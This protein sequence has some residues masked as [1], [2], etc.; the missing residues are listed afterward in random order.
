MMNFF[1]LFSPNYP[2]TIIYMLQSVE[3][4]AGEFIKWFWRTENFKNVAYRR[5]LDKTPKA[6]LLLAVLWLIIVALFILS[7]WLAVVGGQKLMIG[8]GLLVL[9]PVASAHLLVLPLAI[10][11]VLL[12]RPIE[13]RRIAKA[14]HIFA[15]FTGSKIVVLGSYGKTSTKELVATAIGSKLQ[16]ARTEKNLNTPL[17]LAEFAE[18]ISG[19]EEVLVI[20]LGEYRPGDIAEFSSMV[21]PTHAIIT[22]LNSS[23]LD[24]LGSVEEAAANLLSVAQFVP[25]KQLFINEDS[26]LLKSYASDL[27]YASYGRTKV[28]GWKIEKPKTSL[29]GTSFEMKKGRSSMRISSNLLGLHNLPKLALS[30][31]LARSFGA[32]KKQTEAALKNTQPVEHRLQPH[33]VGGATI[34]DDTYNGNIDGVVAA[35]AFV[36]GLRK[37]FKRKIYITPGLVEQGPLTEENHILIGR[38]I[39]PVFDEVVLMRNSV[40]PYIEQG[41]EYGEFNGQLTIVDDPLGFYRQLDQQLARGDLVLMQNDWTDNY[42]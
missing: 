3:Y 32:N 21:R 27:E 40:T 7:V 35:V 33:N 12:Q 13:R 10:G 18:S 31:A 38:T 42:H 17:A 19:N 41:L 25:A 23:H 15:E 16:V 36:S 5:S 37:K 30:A 1:S 39:A 9:M 29:D 34:L 2:K 22:G 6:R 8:L 24:T 4:R 20:E 28:L 11:T 26:D 14:A